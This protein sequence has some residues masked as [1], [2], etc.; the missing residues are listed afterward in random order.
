METPNPQ[1]QAPGGMDQ[2]DPGKECMLAFQAGDEAAFERLI[3]LYSERA[4]AL[5]VRF[6]G[7]HEGCEDLVQDLFLRM[8]KAA[9][10]YQPSAKFTTWMYRI[11]FNLAA[12]HGERSRLRRSQSLSMETVPGQTLGAA[13]LDDSAVEP[14]VDLE[15]DDV[16][17]QVREAIASLPD[18]QR[19]ALILARYEEQS[20]QNIG[21][22]LGISAKAVKSLIHRARETLRERLAHV[23]SGDLS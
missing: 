10:R 2:D 20:Y 1:N 3:G 5:F 15:R 17:R 18:T 19:M 8:W 21:E 4:Y 23:I 11:A 6:L 12:N 14:S 16:V 22:A 9:D 7:R 13:I